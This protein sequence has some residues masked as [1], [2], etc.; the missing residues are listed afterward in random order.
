MH[1]LDI[2]NFIVSIKMNVHAR[3]KAK[4]RKDAFSNQWQVPLDVGSHIWVNSE[5]SSNFMLS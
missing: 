5:L 2:W 1:C 3:L 4:Y